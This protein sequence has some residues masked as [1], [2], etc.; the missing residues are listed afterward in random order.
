M[1]RQAFKI[2]SLFF[3]T[4]FIIGLFIPSVSAELREL[5]TGEEI[6]GSQQS[7]SAAAVERPKVE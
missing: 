1:K 4:V 5:K 2:S 7:V 6:E 3:T